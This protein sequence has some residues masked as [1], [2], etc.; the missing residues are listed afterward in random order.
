[1]IG[2]AFAGIATALMFAMTATMAIAMGPVGFGAAAAAW[3]LDGRLG[4]E[5]DDGY[6]RACIQTGPRWRRSR[7]LPM[8]AP[9]FLPDQR[10]EPLSRDQN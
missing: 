8:N 1:M 7:E 9:L 2:K 10:P 5:P 3:R 6:L 4:N